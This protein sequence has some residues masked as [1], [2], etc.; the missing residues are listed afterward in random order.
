[1]QGRPVQAQHV[2]ERA[3]SASPSRR[4]RSAACAGCDGQEGRGDARPVVDVAVAFFC[5]VMAVLGCQRTPTRPAS[6]RQVSCAAPEWTGDGQQ[7]GDESGG[8]RA[9][10]RVNLCRRAGL[11]GGRRRP[12]GPPRV[13][14]AC[15]GRARGCASVGGPA[16]CARG[17]SGCCVSGGDRQDGGRAVVDEP[18]LQGP[19]RPLVRQRLLCGESWKVRLEVVAAAVRPVDRASQSRPVG[20]GDQAGVH[21]AR[22]AHA[23]GLPASAAPTAVRLLVRPV[24]SGEVVRRRALAGGTA[25]LRR[26]VRRAVVVGR[27]RHGA[28][29]S[30][31]RRSARAG[32][33]AGRG[34][35]RSGR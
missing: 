35:A 14:G 21:A 18:V 23:R 25:V 26:A 5:D 34:G 33:A 2:G 20:A 1:M 15:R 30:R 3:R 24:R 27:G 9:P 13:I 32:R 6:R 10:A 28:A 29:P 12:T 22:R 11:N 19:G 17:R 7:L 31:R 16:R 8:R 4:R